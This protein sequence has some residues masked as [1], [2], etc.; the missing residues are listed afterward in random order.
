MEIVRLLI[1][2]GMIFFVGL[3]IVGILGLKWVS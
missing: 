3:I 1:I 2:A